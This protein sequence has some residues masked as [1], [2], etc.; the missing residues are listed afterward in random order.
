MSKGSGR[1]PLTSHRKSSRDGG[2][3]QSSPVRSPENLAPIEAQPSVNPSPARSSNPSSL[4]INSRSHIGVSASS[5][6]CG[7]GAS[8]RPVSSVSWE[9]QGHN[10]RTVISSSH[11][12]HRPH[13]HHHQHGFGWGERDKIILLV[14]GKRFTVNPN[15]LVKHPNTMLGRCVCHSPSLSHTHTH[16]VMSLY[17]VTVTLFYPVQNV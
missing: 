16:H 9:S 4:D 5:G 1:M 7:E 13:Q 6:H 14:D 17:C 11:S 2:S 15:L 10:E 8:S 3:A 12:Y